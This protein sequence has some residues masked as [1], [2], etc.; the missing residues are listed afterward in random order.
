MATSRKK[1]SSKLNGQTNIDNFRVAEHNYYTLNRAIIS[2]KKITYLKL[3]YE[4][5]ARNYGVTSLSTFY[6]TVSEIIVPS[7]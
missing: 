2:C 5:F 1:R 6:V 4:L 3:T 7:L